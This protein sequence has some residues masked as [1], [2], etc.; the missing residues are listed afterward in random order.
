MFYPA[1]A[2]GSSRAVARAVGVA[3]RLAPPRGAPHLVVRL[4]ASPAATSPTGI[5]PAAPTAAS[6]TEAW[7]WQR[8]TLCVCGCASLAAAGASAHLLVLGGREGENEKG[9]EQVCWRTS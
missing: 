5:V 1:T 2:A 4:L 6:L 9:V 8:S 7:L 3:L